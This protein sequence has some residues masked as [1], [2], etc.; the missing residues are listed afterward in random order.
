[1]YS[2]RIRFWNTIVIVFILISC[3][4]W[5][6]AQNFNY[7]R[8]IVDTLA[9]SSMHGRGYVDSGDR[10]AASYIAEQFKQ[11]NLAHYGE[12]Y[13]QK[14][15][16]PVNSFPGKMTIGINNNPLLPGVDYIVSPG[17]PSTLGEFK[18]LALKVSDILDVAQLIIKIKKANK[19]FLVIDLDESKGLSKKEKEVFQNNLNILKYA[20]DIQ[21]S[22]IVFL[23]SGKLTWSVSPVLETRPM[24][25]IRKQ[26]FNDKIK[27]L[28]IEIDSEYIPSYP[29]QNVIAFLPAST[30]NDSMI[31]F[32]AHYDHLGRM[33][34][35]TLFPGAN[36]NASG[37]AMLLTLA[38]HYAN[39]KDSLK[40]NMV[41][42]AFGGEELGLKG[43]FHFVQ[44]P[45]FPISNIKFLVNMDISG[46]GDDGIQ[47]VNGSVYKEEFNQLVRINQN[48][49]YLPQIKIRGAA[50]N[51]DHCPFYKNGVPSF[52]IYTLG[53]I[54]AYHDVF[55]KAETL[56]LT[57]Y[58]NYFKLLTGFVNEL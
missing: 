56:P 52:F 7:A 40:Y 35:N 57:A 12:D 31:V 43:S 18:V 28:V 50:C 21:I 53:G 8:K 4:E 48:N 45:L 29:T 34:K 37:I 46:T 39:R 58:D 42:M 55:D 23:T 19:K 17:C 2:K 47:V 11:L 16:I 1:M 51:S 14:F 15:N 33:G 9:S 49:N 3:P 24:V 26:S 30:K 5:V 13:Y 38:E 41:F 44:N 32:T 6:F 27:S 36:D 22:G 20:Q 54:Q 10:K 25:T